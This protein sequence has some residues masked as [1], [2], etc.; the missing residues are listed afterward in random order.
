MGSAHSNSTT[1][2]RP[3][4][5]ELLTEAVAAQRAGNPAE[6]ARLAQSILGRSPDHPDA[7]QILAVALAQ[8]GRPTEASTV[9]R[10]AL[11]I[12]PNDSGLHFNFGILLNRTGDTD[13]A[14]REFRAAVAAAPDHVEGL[15][16]LGH[17]L[18]E[19]GDLDGADGFLRRALSVRPLYAR[20]W[21][22]LASNLKT[23]GRLDEAIAA[24]QR[25]IALNPNQIVARIT[26]ANIYRDTGRAREALELLRAALTVEPD[27]GAALAFLYHQLQQCCDWRDLP[28]LGGRLDAADDAAI[29]AGRTPPEP[30]FAQLA[31][32]DD[33][34]S[35]LSLAKAHARAFDRI[36][37]LPPAPRAATDEP[38][39]IAYLGN[40]LQDHPV[41][42]LLASLVPRHDR[43]RFHVSAYAWGA[44][45][46]SETRRKLIAG[47]D[48]CV[49]IGALDRDAAAQRIRADG[50]EIL[51]DTKGQTQGHRLDIMARR[52]A[53][54][55]ATFLGF[56]GTSGAGFIDYVIADRIVLPPE[57][58]NFFAEAPAW[59]PHCYMP[60]GDDA[61]ATVR[62][63]DVRAGSPGR[64]A[65][66]GLPETGA[67]LASFNNG[68]KIE[69]VL[70]EAWMRILAA[71]QGAVLWL[72]RYNDLVAGNLRGEAAKRGIDPARLVFADR[73]AR[74]VHLAR[75]AL[76]DLALDTRLF[77]GH[78]T[79]LDALRAGLP[80]VTMLGRHFA[81]RVAASLLTA[82]GMAELIA[83]DVETYV[84]RVL[85]LLR[86]PAALA[87]MRRRLAD[88]RKTAPLF[89]AAGYAR[90]FDRLLMA[91]AARHRAG[92]APAP[93]DLA[94]D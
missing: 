70:F 6:A 78:A 73:P 20:G 83:P 9:F 75:L 54:V 7:L 88:A 89:D 86:D 71:T 56:P 1:D 90:D 32:I 40:D 13:G 41:G 72:H 85:G 63:E 15:Y 23:Q 44:D 55:Q 43:K 67:V 65:E 38:I 79:S 31:R 51:I 27:N 62:S 84:A 48:N 94:G 52:P 5:A 35:N 47:L 2:P 50:I 24:S 37:P 21:S 58:R 3:G 18:Q 34:A 61:P 10:R 59:L 91:M 29:A 45:D 87:S 17:L 14:E 46:G 77:N 82:S 42:Q 26:L 76:A 4:E 60:P 25:A 28:A 22:A 80:V 30:A 92:Q 49:D 11:A 64:R 36:A 57:H 12:T 33:P 53:P 93:I 8:L 74:T 16:S 68:Y 81:S 39:R 66:W 19:R 69:P